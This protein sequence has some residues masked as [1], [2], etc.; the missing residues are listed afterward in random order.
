[1]P[2]IIIRNYF[3]WEKS[4][5]EATKSFI[6]K[7]WLKQNVKHKKFEIIYKNL[8]KKVEK[9]ELGKLWKYLKIINKNDL[10]SFKVG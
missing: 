6:S 8:R 1:M 10:K 2:F 7:S 5:D 9:Y 3:H 4:N